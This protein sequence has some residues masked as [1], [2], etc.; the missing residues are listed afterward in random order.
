MGARDIEY[1]ELYTTDPQATV[2]HYAESLG[3]APVARAAG[4]GYASVLLRQGEVQLVVTGGAG[5]EGYL[6][7]HGDGVADL[8]FRCDDAERTCAAAQAAGARVLPAGPGGLAVSAFGSVRHTLLT[9]EPDGTPRLPPGRDWIPVHEPAPPAGRVRELDHVAVCLEAGTLAD[10]T[11]FYVAAFGLERY[12]SDY[13]AFA[14][15]AMDSVVVRTPGGGATFT[16]IEPDRKKHAG[17][18]DAFLDGNNGPGVQHLAFLVDDI[19]DAVLQYAGRGV[20]FL[21][22]VGAY[23]DMLAER[24]PDLGAE[25]GRLRAANVLVDRDEWGDL[26]QIFT[27]SPFPRNTLFSELVQRRG[28]RGFGSANIRALYEAIELDRNSGAR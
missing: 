22:T 7:V 12:S 25:V 4:P 20:S 2:G 27:G 16:L 19:V 28:A 23:Y 26:L 13:V 14:D 21:S 17:Q 24:F 15:Q 1:V 3:F 8:A 6:E 10:Y 18:I 5:I 9:A 11:E